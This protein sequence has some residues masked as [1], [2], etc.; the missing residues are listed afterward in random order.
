MSQEHLTLNHSCNKIDIYLQIL[1]LFCLP[2]LGLALLSPPVTQVADLGVSLDF[3]HF[4]SLLDPS[5]QVFCILSLEF[6]FSSP[7]LFTVL[8]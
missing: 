7:F 8:V 1:S 5:P 3:C 4:R 2:V 6:L